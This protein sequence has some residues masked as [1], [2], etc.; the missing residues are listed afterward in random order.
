MKEV[1]AT[2][3]AEQLKREIPTASITTGQ[4]HSFEGQ[5]VHYV[6]IRDRHLF[7][8]YDAYRIYGPDEQ[9]ALDERFP[10]L[11]V[12]RALFAAVRKAAK[13][14]IDGTQEKADDLADLL[15][16][17]LNE[18]EDAY[19]HD[20]VGCK[21]RPDCRSRIL[22]EATVCGTCRYTQQQHD[23]R[24]VGV[25]C[26]TCWRTTAQR[27]EAPGHPMQCEECRNAGKPIPE[28]YATLI[29][30]KVVL[31]YDRAY[32]VACTETGG[33]ALLPAAPAPST[34]PDCAAEIH[35]AAV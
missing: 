12:Q 28:R 18:E 26:A 8:S 25:D 11:R 23:D 32:D 13:T 17:I 9:E 21:E 14:L 1:N 22:G 20:C 27:T 31:D 15:K 24:V 6:E 2:K 34:D 4:T 19:R 16:A 30:E 33:I 7:D 35:D 29:Q 10:Q 3:L 5:P